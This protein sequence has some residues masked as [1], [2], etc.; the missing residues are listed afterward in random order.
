[1]A[2]SDSSV[3]PQQPDYFDFNV[4][5][6]C[7]I[8]SIHNQAMAGRALVCSVDG[9]ETSYELMAVETMFATVM[10][11]LKDMARKVDASCYDYIK[12]DGASINTEI[13][14]ADVKLPER[15]VIEKMQ[16]MTEHQKNKFVRYSI[17]LLNND[18]KVKRLSEM[19]ESGQI[20]IEQLMDRM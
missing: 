5:L 4:N 10:N 16:N 1:M 18:P 17:R 12:K 13:N 11:G 15:A 6:G 14:S 19:Y 7:D 3:K 9:Y 8:W 20:T 2:N